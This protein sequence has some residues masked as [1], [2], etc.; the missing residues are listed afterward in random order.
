MTIRSVVQ[1]S[2]PT[3]LLYAQAKFDDTSAAATPITPVSI[4]RKTR[5]LARLPKQQGDMQCSCEV[6]LTK[7]Q[8][9]YG[10]SGNNSSSE[11]VIINRAN[12]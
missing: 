8:Q 9:K 7:L 4:T 11:S 3:T 6:A 12:M 5:L 10:I 1:P 2:V